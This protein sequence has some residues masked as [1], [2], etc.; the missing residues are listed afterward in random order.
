MK[1]PRR[2]NQNAPL[3]K[4][5]DLGKMRCLVKHVTSRQVTYWVMYPSVNGRPCKM[6]FL[7]CYKSH[8]YV[9]F[10]GTFDDTDKRAAW[11]AMNVMQRLDAE[12][13]QHNAK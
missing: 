2:P 6:T 10:T 1:T 13:S 8:D 11:L 4:V 7:D 3:E 5:Q 12:N 9:Q